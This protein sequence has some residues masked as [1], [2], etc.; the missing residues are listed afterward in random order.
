[1]AYAPQQGS[2]DAVPLL[3]GGL[4]V[5]GTSPYTPLHQTGPTSWAPVDTCPQ[6]VHHQLLGGTPMLPWSSKSNGGTGLMTGLNS[7]VVAHKFLGCV[8]KGQ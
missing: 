8:Y 4:A 3:C 7:L 5:Q 6:A 2:C 1:M